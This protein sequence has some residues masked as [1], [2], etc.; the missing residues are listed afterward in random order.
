M[1]LVKN[2]PH[3][4]NGQQVIDFVLS[5]KGQKLWADNF[6]RPVVGELS[7]ISPEAAAKF[8]PD[9]EYARAGSID[10]ARMAEVQA[11]FSEAYLQAMK[12]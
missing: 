9:S 8:L 7:K 2:A 1:S 6:L 4:A 12:S 11:A 5:E 3:K 10:Y